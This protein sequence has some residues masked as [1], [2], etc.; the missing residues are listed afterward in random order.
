MPLVGPST[1]QSLLLISLIMK[2]NLKPVL[3]DKSFPAVDEAGRPSGRFP[4]GALCEA[5]YGNSLYPHNPS[6][7]ES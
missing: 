7:A 2:R 1:I 6:I 3:L 4:E 5:G